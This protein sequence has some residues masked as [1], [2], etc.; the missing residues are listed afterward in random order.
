[1]FRRQSKA[2]NGHTADLKAAT[3]RKNEEFIIIYGENKHKTSHFMELS[4]F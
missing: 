4:N 3:Q 1:M 2:E